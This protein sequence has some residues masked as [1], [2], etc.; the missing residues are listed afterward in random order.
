LVPQVLGLGVLGLLDF[1]LREGGLQTINC[2]SGIIFLVRVPDD[3]H[4]VII[5][6]ALFPETVARR[7]LTNGF[8]AEARTLHLPA[9]LYVELSGCLPLNVLGKVVNVFILRD[10]PIS[11][12]L[13]LKPLR[14]AHVGRTFDGKLC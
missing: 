13:V 2:C 11:E 3:G 5:L 6:Q 12:Q 14:G 9:L 8:H 10:V 7:Q 1:L 4:H